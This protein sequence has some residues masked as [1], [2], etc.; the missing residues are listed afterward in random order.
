M[1]LL[2]ISEPDEI[3]AHAPLQK[4][5][6]VGIDLGTTNSLIATIEDDKPVLLKDNNNNDIIPSVVHYSKND[7]LVGMEA[8]NKKLSDPTNTISSVKRFMG[9]GFSDI[10]DYKSLPYQFIQ[11]DGLIEINTNCG[12]KNP[13]EIASDILKHLKQIANNHFNR[14]VTDAIITV[15]AYFNESQRLATIQAAKLANINVMRLLNEPTAAAIAYGLDNQ[16]NIQEQTKDGAKCLVFD[17]GG[18][19]LDISIL[20]LYQGVFE[21][22]AV[23]GDTMLGGDDF[24]YGLYCYI[25]EKEH[26]NALT[27]EDTALLLNTC[28]KIKERLSI[29]MD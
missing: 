29:Q 23:N 15:P 27:N 22:I 21:V 11:K 17:L 9:I 26:L 2:Q 1:A 5:I 4:K 19:T 13:I 28:K 18:G 6:I 14:E 24:D 25:L 7:I 12:I 10:K 3:L 20:R 16:N 8:Y